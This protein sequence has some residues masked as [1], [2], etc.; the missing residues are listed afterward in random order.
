V[1]C[2]YEGT[3]AG[4][5]RRCQA[6]V[7]R[8]VGDRGCRPQRASPVCQ[9]AWSRACSRTCQPALECRWRTDTGAGRDPRTGVRQ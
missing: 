3:P 8:R 9:Q 4:R 6:P 2:A 1:V 5:H 7:R